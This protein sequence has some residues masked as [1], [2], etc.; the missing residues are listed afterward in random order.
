[1]KSSMV[2]AAPRFH[3]AL[4]PDD[5]VV[6]LARTTIERPASGVKATAAAESVRVAPSRVTLVPVLIA[7]VSFQVPLLLTVM[8]LEVGAL[9]LAP[10][11][12]WP[13]LTTMGP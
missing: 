12:H 9:L 5:V 6:E 1:M 2:F 7:L 11:F 8:G 10:S 13:P 3:A 4:P